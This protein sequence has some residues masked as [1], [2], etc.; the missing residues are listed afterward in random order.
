MLDKPN[1]IT[2]QI[3]RKLEYIVDN[4]YRSKGISAENI[5]SYFSQ[6]KNFKTLIKSL[7]DL[8]ILY[9]NLNNEISFEDK[10]KEILFKKI[11]LDRI[12]FEKD[13]P[14]NEKIVTKYYDF[15]S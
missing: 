5:Q 14:Q 13:N 10:V 1:T 7:S 9:N 4:I 3:N 6:K 8:E 15:I 12:Y 2:Q 11:L